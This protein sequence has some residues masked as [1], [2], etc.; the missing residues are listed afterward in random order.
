MSERRSSAEQE[1][2]A[3]V[4]REKRIDRLLKKVSVVAWTVTTLVVLAFA[5]FAGTQIVELAR[6]AAAGRLPWSVVAGSMIPVVTVLGLF[7]VLVATLTTIMIFLRLRT[8]SLAEIQLRLAAL[9]NMMAS[10][11]DSDLETQG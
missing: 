6:A 2:W 1:A 8:A 7:S 3:L 11:R 10:Q 4:D 9:E 5:V